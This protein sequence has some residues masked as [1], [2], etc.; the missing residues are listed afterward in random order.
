[1]TY[2]VFS[3]ARP[4]ASA[5]WR[6]ALER[7]GEVAVELARGTRRRASDERSDAQAD[8]PLGRGRRPRRS[9]RARR[10][11]RRPTPW[12]G[13]R[14]GEGSTRGRAG[15]EG[16]RRTRACPSWRPPIPTRAEDVVGREP[17]GP[18]RR[19]SRPGRR[20]TG[21]PSRGRAGAGRSRGRAARRRRRDRPRRRL[22]AGDVSD[23]R[24]GRL[25]RRTR[26]RRPPASRA[27]RRRRRRRATGVGARVSAMPAGGRRRAAR[28]HEAATREERG[29]GQG[30]SARPRRSC[31][32]YGPRHRAG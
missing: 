10:G 15:V 8:H 28:R 13:A 11:H 19:P 3:G 2:A 23:G 7:A 27:V 29:E 4:G 20:A 30:Q 24:R 21:R 1:M 22:E 32:G 12:A 25:G 18:R 31:R 17:V 26:C 6:I 14:L 5:A 16:R 9:D